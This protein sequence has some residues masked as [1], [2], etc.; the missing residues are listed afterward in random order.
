MTATHGLCFSPQWRASDSWVPLKRVLKKHWG[1]SSM[2]H[3]LGFWPALYCFRSTLHWLFIEIDGLVQDC[4]ISIADAM[5]MPQS[6]SQPSKLC[7]YC[8]CWFTHIFNEK[9]IVLSTSFHSSLFQIMT[10]R[11]CQISGYMNKYYMTFERN[12]W[13]PNWWYQCR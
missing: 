4:A 11:N 9:N 3:T 6:C 5:E 13:F 8:T 12:F 1:K 10:F 7:T 2:M